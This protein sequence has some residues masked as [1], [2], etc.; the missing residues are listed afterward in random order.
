LRSGH[1]RIFYEVDETALQ[2][3]IMAVGHKDHNR[4]FIR[5]QEVQL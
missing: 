5:G 4:L 3:T 2:V 1:Y